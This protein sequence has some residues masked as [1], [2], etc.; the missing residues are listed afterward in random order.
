[1]DKPPSESCC[2]SSESLYQEACTRVTPLLREPAGNLAEKWAELEWQAMWYSGAFGTT[3]RTVSGAL[4]EIIQFGFWNREPGP[5]FVHAS[6]RVDGKQVL[7][8]DIE[9]DMHVADWDRHGHSQNPAF[10]RVVLHLFLRKSG[11]SHFTRTTQNREV[12]QIHLQSE[13]D[14]QHLHPPI[15]HPGRC[16]APLGQVAGRTVDSLIETA[17][18]VRMRRKADQLRRAAIAHGMDE[19]LFQAFAV[20][21]G[22]K[23]NKIP[24]LVLAQRAKLQLLRDQGTAAESLLFGVAGFL[25][26]RKINRTASV[27]QDYWRHLWQYW[28]QLRSQF[29]HLI[30]RQDLWRFGMTRPSNHPHRRLGALAELVRRW[31]EVRLLPPRLED[32]AEWIGGLSHPFWD[33]HFTLTSRPTVQPFHLLGQTR[34]NEILANVIHPMLVATN[35]S[36]WESYKKIRAELSNRHLTI[37]CR[38]LFGETDRAREHLRFLYQQ[39]GLLQI[40]EDFCLAD[41]TNCASCR[42]PEMIAKLADG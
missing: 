24:F 29:A 20:A 5:D 2:F 23:L 33:H 15:A 28:W 26:D 30:L 12:V 34:V 13:I 38:R 21:L 11:T 39:Q 36:D 8:G 9:M 16:C 25:E 37:V 1:M 7:E 35:Q 42:F 41:S 18:R 32:L 31:K 22:Y 27:D 4:V 19:A 14:L 40:F 6:L 3:F 10:D 17:A